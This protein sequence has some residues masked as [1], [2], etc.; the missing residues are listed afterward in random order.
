MSDDVE[1]SSF[2]EGKFGFEKDP[3]GLDPTI[4]IRNLS[5]VVYFIYMI[6]SNNNWDADFIY[7]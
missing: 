1:F 2:K 3:T 7:F 4:C 6:D 5:K